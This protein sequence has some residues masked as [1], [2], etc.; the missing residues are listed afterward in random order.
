VRVELK[1]Y[2]VPFG[3][4]WYGLNVGSAEVIARLDWGANGT[5]NSADATTISKQIEARIK[6]LHGT[7]FGESGQNSI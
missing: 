1:A 5:A 6:L 3:S 7:I 2:W 4:K